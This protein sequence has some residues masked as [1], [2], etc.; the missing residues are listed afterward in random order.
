MTGRV[1]ANVAT[2]RAWAQQLIV[3]TP[4][5]INLGELRK[6]LRDITVGTVS[7][8]VFGV[9]GVLGQSIGEALGAVQ[10]AADDSLSK[11]HRDLYRYWSNALE[12]ANRLVSDDEAAGQLARQQLSPARQSGEPKPDTRGTPGS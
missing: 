7:Y 8:G 1:E 12:T 10:S 4:L 3:Q 9:F 2:I 11:W 5:C 6:K